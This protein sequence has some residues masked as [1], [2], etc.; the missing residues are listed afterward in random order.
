MPIIPHDKALHI[1]YGAFI[2]SVVFVLSLVTFPYYALCIASATVIAAA[3]GKELCDFW[4]NLQAKKKNLIPTHGVEA[5]D[6]IA[7]IAGGIVVLV[8]LLCVKYLV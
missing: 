6:A 8:P 1:L 4:S 3:V 2:F 5:W 7:T